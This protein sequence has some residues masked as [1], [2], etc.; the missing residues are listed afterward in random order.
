MRV[1][2]HRQNLVHNPTRDTAAL[3]VCTLEFETGGWLRATSE[4]V[5]RMPG[6]IARIRSDTSHVLVELQLFDAGQAL[7]W[8]LDPQRWRSTVCAR[9]SKYLTS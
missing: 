9:L 5:D 4:V 6:E 1:K 2:G 7:A 8:N 3:G